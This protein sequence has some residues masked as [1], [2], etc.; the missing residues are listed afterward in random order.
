MPENKGFFSTIWGPITAGAL[1]GAIAAL[2]VYWGNP[3]NMG[4]CVACFTR[5]IAGSLGLHRAAPV[6]YLRPE[7]PAMALGAMLAALM[8]KEFRPRAGSAAIA[9]FVLG[10]FAMLGALVFLGCTWRVLLRLGGGDANAL[11]G[12]AGLC[13]GVGI[14]I[15]FLKTG[16]SLGR[17][18]PAPSAVGYV[19]PVIALALVALAFWNP[20][21]GSLDAATQQPLGPLFSTPAEKGPGAQHA[22]IWISLLGGALIGFLAQRSRFCTIGAFR[23]VVLTKDGHLLYA[24]I[25]LVAA[26]LVIN[27]ALGKFKWGFEGQPI[28]HTAH[29][30]NFLSMTLAG[31]AF[32]L[33]GGCPGRQVV[34]AGEGD[35][36]AGVFVAGMLTGAAFSHNFALASSTKGPS[37]FGPAA[38]II[39]LIVCVIIGLVMREPREA[40]A[41]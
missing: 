23:N 12:L 27:V 6:Q 24:V 4:L 31:L 2:L 16:Y 34:L 5:D 3:G 17:S 8:S 15:V 36:D 38:V 26:N 10:I 11:L 7:L 9:R 37:E 29:L 1:I 25:A 22:A 40:A 14:S 19:A 13:A 30:W 18:R 39:G 21:F 35:S 33:G 28:A 20:K 32:A 41:A